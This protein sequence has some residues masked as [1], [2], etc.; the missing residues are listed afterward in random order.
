M[1]P[2]LLQN[3]EFKR[4]AGVP[5]PDFDRIDAVPVRTLAARQQK[6]D[7]SGCRTVTIDL[8]DI[9]KRFAEMPAF[10]MRFQIEQPDDVGRGQG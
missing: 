10:R 6:I 2:S 9:A 1:R 5:M 8:P 7:R 4:R 3:F